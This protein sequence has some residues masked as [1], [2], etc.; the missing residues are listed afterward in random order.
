MCGTWFTFCFFIISSLPEYL[1]PLVAEDPLT[2]QGHGWGGAVMHILDAALSA[3]LELGLSA[4]RVVEARIPGGLAGLMFSSLAKNK[5]SHVFFY[6]LALPSLCWGLDLWFAGAVYTHPSAV[7]CSHSPDS[8][9]VLF[10]QQPD[11]Q[12][13]EQGFFLP[14]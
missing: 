10:A 8:P 5:E 1:K 3:G 12:G 9:A 14:S 11:C 4:S 6:L 2:Q 13:R 7:S